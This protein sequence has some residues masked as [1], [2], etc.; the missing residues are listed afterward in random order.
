[1][2]ASSLKNITQADS[3]CQYKA[4]PFFNTY[5]REVDDYLEIWLCS[6]WIRSGSGG[7]QTTPK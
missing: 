7:D 1:M 6:S 5:K 4:P 3:F 2:A